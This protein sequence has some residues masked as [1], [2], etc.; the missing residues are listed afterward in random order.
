MKKSQ[1]RKVIRK[2]ISEQ[3][4]P[5]G[6]YTLA[7]GCPSDNLGSGEAFWNQTMNMGCSEILSSSWA[8]TNS[9]AIQGFN[10]FCNGGTIS[11]QTSAAAPTIGQM[12]SDQQCAFCACWNNQSNISGPQS[13]PGTGGGIKTPFKGKKR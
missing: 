5:D 7:S 10:D 12:N 2:I 6:V 8:P 11:S 4:T 9:F 3:L 13:K 1:L